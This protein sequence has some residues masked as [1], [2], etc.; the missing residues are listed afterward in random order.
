MDACIPVVLIHK[1]S[2]QRF[3]FRSVNRAAKFFDVSRSRIDNV[4]N[5]PVMSFRGFRITT[6]VHLGI[7]KEIEEMNLRK[8]QKRNTNCR[9]SVN[10]RIFF[11]FDR[12]K[13]Y[14]RSFKHES[15]LCSALGLSVNL[16][17]RYILNRQLHDK[18]IIVYAKNFDP[19]NIKEYL[20]DLSCQAAIFPVKIAP[21]ANSLQHNE[22][23]KNVK[24]TDYNG[25][26][27]P[28]INSL[29]HNEL[30]VGRSQ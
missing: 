18:Y 26:G 23:H 21:P 4:I 2:N 3:E 7:R 27:V 5:N 13:N 14:I 22:L 11:V 30:Y 19:N 6:S 10:K 29:Y 9:V 28:F 17:W 12:N 15:K 20:V 8:E 1:K 24:R 25:Q 16:L